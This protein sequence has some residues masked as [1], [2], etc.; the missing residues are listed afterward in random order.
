MWVGATESTLFQ[1]FKKSDVLPLCGQEVGLQF[2][3]TH[4]VS[5]CGKPG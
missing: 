2:V 3:Q 1:D 5:A 4:S